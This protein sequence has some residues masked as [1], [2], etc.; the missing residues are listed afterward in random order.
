MLGP[1]TRRLEYDAH[2]VGKP[3]ITY[4][5]TYKPAQRGNI[6]VLGGKTGYND[7]AR[8]CLVLAAKIDGRPTSCRSSPTRGR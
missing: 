2:P 4:N 7:D 5:N 6:Q 8:Y 1:V 3:P